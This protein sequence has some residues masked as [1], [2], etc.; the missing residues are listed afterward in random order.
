MPGATTAL[1]VL[2]MFNLFDFPGGER[3]A[4]A[5]A[6]I[7]PALAALRARFDRARAPVIHVNDNFA[8]WRDDFAGLQARCLAAGGISARLASTLAPAAAH[9]HVPKPR[10]SG[11]TCT[12]LPVL[13]EDLGVRRVVVAGIA[14]DACVLATALDA[15]MRDYRVW[16][17][18]DCVASRTPTLRRQALAL[19]RHSLQLHTSPS[20]AVS[21]IFP[22]NSAASGG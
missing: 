6:H 20:H 14:A 1:L 10:H 22:R 13:L 16:V 8:H 7:L 3:L 5:S 21:G 11:F 19:L 2:D 9:Y 17:P 12:A 18:G 4:R 15:H